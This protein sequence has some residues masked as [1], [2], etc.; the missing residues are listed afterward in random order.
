MLTQHGWAFAGTLGSEATL[1]GVDRSGRAA[2]ATVLLERKGKVRPVFIGTRATCC[3]LAP[4]ARIVADAGSVSVADLVNVDVRDLRFEAHL[5]VEE[6]SELP[7][8]LWRTLLTV[9][10]TERAGT[11]VL[12]LRNRAASLP[13]WAHSFERRGR[14]YLVVRRDNLATELEQDWRDSWLTLCRSIHYPAGEDKVRFPLASLE[15]LTWA[16]SAMSASR[17]GYSLSFDTLQF[18]WYV[19]LKL[20]QRTPL[21]VERGACAFTHTHDEQAIRVWWDSSSWC[22]V[23]SGFVMAPGGA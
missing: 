21:P 14:R 20:Q 23:I 18:S 19:D 10:Q 16:L 22:P 3:W 13:T 8:S 1:V 7:A 12:P 15:L 11:M 17:I 6:V 2:R 9:A 5:Q 4:E